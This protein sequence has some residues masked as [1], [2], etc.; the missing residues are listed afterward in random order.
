M[1]TQEFMEQLAR[2]SSRFVWRLEAD[3]G[4]NAERRRRPRMLIRATPRS[5]PHVDISFGPMGALWYAISG[6]VVEPRDWARAGDLLG[7]PPARAADL[8]AAAND[9]TWAGAEGRREPVEYL[10]TLRE[11]LEA[12]V[13]LSVPA[14]AKK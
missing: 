11:R 14:P 12:A 13:G 3:S 9:A 6:D 10:Q 8:R 7:L 5:G 2:A 4:V 1:T